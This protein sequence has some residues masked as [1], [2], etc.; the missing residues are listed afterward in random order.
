MSNIKTIFRRD[1]VAYFTS[2]IG[3]IFIIVYLLISVGLYMTTFFT[4]PVADMRGYFN[5]LP[6]LL[7]VFI[8][9]VT[10]RV[11]AEE[12]KENTWEMLL[13]FP[14]RARELVLGKFLASLAFFAIT[15]ASTITVPIMLAKLGSPDNGAILSGY[16]GTLFVGAF[17]LAIGIFFSGLCKDQIVAFVVTLLACFAI[18]LLGTDFVA[19]YID[20]VFRDGPFNGFGS[21]LSV[22][23]GM[24]SH[25]GAFTRGVIE[26]VDILY[27]TVWTILFLVLNMMFVE[28]R[29]RA[30][31][32]ATF[33]VAT[34]VCI[35]IGI[36]FN[37][38][39]HDQ[40]FGRKDMTENKIYTV[41]DATKDILSSLDADVMVNIYIT[42]KDEMPTGYTGLEQD[43]TDKLNDLR[44]ASNGHLKY[45][46]IPMRAKHLID[47]QKGFTPGEEEKEK[48]DEERIEERMYDKGV[49]PFQVQAFDADQVTNKLVYS[50]L[51]VAYKDKKEEIIPQ[52]IPQTLQEL[53]YRLVNI[54][55]KLTREK[56]PIIALVAPKDSVPPD[57]RRIYMQMGQ[58]VPPEVDPYS[59]LEKW[60][61]YE[62][63]DV[64]RVALTKDSP[65]PDE[66]DTLV[67]INPRELNDR[68]R[69]EINRALV[70]GKPVVMAVQQY[71]W[72]YRVD[73]GQFTLSQN[74]INPN[75]NELLSAYGLGVSK[76]ILMDVNHQALT[77]SSGNALQDLFNMAQPVNLPFH[78]YVTETTM[79]QDASITNWLTNVFYFWGTAL[80]VEK[81]KLA[82]LGLTCQ[83]LMTTTDRAWTIP[84]NA[85]GELLNQA[86]TQTEEG[87]EQYT[88]MAMI[89]GQFPDAF[90]DKPRPA[91]PPA[92]AQPGMPPPPPDDDEGEPEPLTPAPGKLILLGTA[93]TFSDNFIREASNAD[94]ILNSIDALSAGEEL[95]NVRGKKPINRLIERPSDNVR[96]FWK[97][98][99]YVVINLLVAA[100]GIAVMVSRRRARA[101]Y[102]AAYAA[103]HKRAD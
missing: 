74:E 66:Y 77:I 36:A 87:D 33:S 40:S 72:N 69:Y 101:A 97:T 71:N 37:F 73:R 27:F 35:G 26:V 85:E 19:S 16:L 57:M 28:G 3:Y 84:G 9:A 86:L 83:P 45:A 21:L 30:G 13:T 61:Q 38:V 52:V 76:D 89:T 48:T 58:P 90:K 98:I 10:M 47:T 82:E 31:G 100:V 5:N 91:Y 65:L 18:F 39:I 34:A 96:L 24:L 88:L 60:L 55:Y 25:Y 8:P 11:W 17:F 51:G 81:D 12:R 79:S 14:M 93:L 15:L 50:S 102:A 22:A 78:I 49:A 64:R 59:M 43:I 99:N 7:C 92:Q 63:Y 70:S 56:D 53:E 44:L 94:L 1:F 80:T 2:P 23:V 29:G 41:S 67:V 4:Y 32:R 42:P 62:K 46:S 20:S 6:I 95:I 75:V 54:V 68:Q 103:K